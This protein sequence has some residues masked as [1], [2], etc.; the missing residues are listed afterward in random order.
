VGLCVV[1]GGS[2][3]EPTGKTIDIAAVQGNTL[4]LPPVVDRDDLERVEA[5]AEL[6]LAATRL[7]DEAA[8]GPPAVAVW[9]ENALDADPRSDPELGAAVAEALRILEGGSLLAGVLLD[10]QDEGTF[11]NTIAQFDASGQIV[12]VYEKR[13][14]VPFGEYVPWRSV[15][16]DF[17]PLRAIANDGMPGTEPGVFEVAGAR[18]GPVTCFESIFP[19]IVHSQVR[20]GADVLVVTT[21]NASF[22]RTPASA[23]HLTFSQLRAV[24]TGRWVLHAGISGISAV[25]DPRGRITERTELFEQAIVRADLPL[26]EA[27]TLATRVGDWPGR[28]A[29]AAS[30]LGIAALLVTRRRGLA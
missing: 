8:E 3:P 20:A 7:L 9:P 28:I 15:L 25:V 16:G 19:N 14:L 17:P 29:L 23:Q 18:I 13:K 5:V 12:D 1:V 10:G 2:P 30:A 11:L 21:N 6:Q 22:G 26:I 27:R 24:E 4:E